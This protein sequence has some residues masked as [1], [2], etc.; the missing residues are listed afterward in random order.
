MSARLLIM[1]LN[2]DNVKVVADPRVEDLT[3]IFV[4]RV[5]R[6]SKTRNNK[7]LSRATPMV[8]LPQGFLSPTQTQETCLVSLPL[9]LRVPPSPPLES[10]RTE[11][12]TGERGTMTY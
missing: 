10:V 3:K 2:H 7:I 8:F 11:G 6:Y 4:F 12:S 9:T 1:K 5:S